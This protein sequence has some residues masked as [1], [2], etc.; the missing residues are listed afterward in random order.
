MCRDYFIPPQHWLVG[1][2]FTYQMSLFYS[3]CEHNELWWQIHFFPLPSLSSPTIYSSSNKQR[4]YFSQRCHKQ[5]LGQRFRLQY[6]WSHWLGCISVAYGTGCQATSAVVTLQNI[7]ICSQILQISHHS[8]LSKLSLIISP[9]PIPKQ[10]WKW[11]D[12]IRRLFFFS[13]RHLSSPILYYLK[14]GSCVEA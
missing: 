5:G 11:T 6:R 9:R 3:P 4:H 13:R 7:L 12:Y 2:T 10:K 14:R 1:S 8:S